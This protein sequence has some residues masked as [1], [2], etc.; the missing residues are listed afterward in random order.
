[1]LTSIGIILLAIAIAH[2]QPLFSQIAQ[3]RNEHRKVLFETPQSFPS[4]IFQDLSK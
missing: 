3:Y 1:M 2:H 4:W